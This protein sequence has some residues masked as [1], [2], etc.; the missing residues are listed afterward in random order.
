MAKFERMQPFEP[1]AANLSKPII[2]SIYYILIHTFV[3]HPH[4]CA[5]A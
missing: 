2:L 3:L 4:R 1:K 5:G